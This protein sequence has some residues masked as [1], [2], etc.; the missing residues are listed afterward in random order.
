MNF[1][2][3][4]LTLSP[5]FP[6]VLTRALA[7]SLPQNPPYTFISLLLGEFAHRRH[8]LVFTM[9][10]PLSGR[11]TFVSTF[12]LVLRTP[13]PRPLDETS[14]VVLLMISAQKKMLFWFGAPTTF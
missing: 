3:I 8:P 12:F 10:F 14:F 5:F 9:F 2:I 11:E 6:F 7:F 13:F 1:P 4:Y